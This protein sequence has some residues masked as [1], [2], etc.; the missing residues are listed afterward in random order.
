MK[1]LKHITIETLSRGH[2]KISAEKWGKVRTAI[3]T[4]S[5]A[6]DE[7][8]D[9]DNEKRHKQGYKQLMKYLKA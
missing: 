5:S 4:D 3:I 6:V 8:R 2:Y 1:P 7:Y 9:K